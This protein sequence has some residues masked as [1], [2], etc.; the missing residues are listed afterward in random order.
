MVNEFAFQNFAFRYNKTMK[1][2]FYSQQSPLFFI[3]ETSKYLLQTF[4]TIG[5]VG[6][7]VH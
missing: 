6:T 4:E 1:I 3:S 5:T 2:S 7:K